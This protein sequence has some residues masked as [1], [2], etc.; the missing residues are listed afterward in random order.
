MHPPVSAVQ[1]EALRALREG[2]PPTFPR[3]AAAADLNPATV[4]ERALRDNWPKRRFPR[5]GSKASQIAAPECEAEAEPLSDMPEGMSLEDVRKRLA[6]VM[7][8]LLGKAV[9]LAERGVLDKARIDALLSMGRL[10]EQSEAVAQASAAE[11]QKRSDDELAAM[12]ERIDERI[13]ELAQAYAERLGGAEHR[14]GAC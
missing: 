11:Q 3:L 10:L 8:R 7:P 1:W 6:E 13:I 5:Q 14:D 2:A 9:A 4:R 12:L